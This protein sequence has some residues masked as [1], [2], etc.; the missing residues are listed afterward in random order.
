[1]KKMS[2]EEAIRHLGTV[3][4]T[5]NPKLEKGMRLVCVKIEGDI[6]KSMAD[7][8]RDTGRSYY[9]NNK[10]VPHHPSLPGN[11]PAPDTG[12]L[13]NSISSAVENKGYEVHGAVGTT[14]LDPPYGAYLENGTSTMQ[15]RP[16]LAPA[17]AQNEDF[18]RETFAACIQ[19]AFGGR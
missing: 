17:V 16:W 6:K 5:I 18:I 11:P 3:N 12:R 2:I 13:R 1:M 14:Q 15:P 19:G 8:P 7:T 10:K 4:D 9:T